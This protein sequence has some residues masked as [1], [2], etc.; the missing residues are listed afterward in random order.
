MT[1][2]GVEGEETARIYKVRRPAAEMKFKHVIFTHRDPN[3]S[4][5]L[6][7]VSVIIKAA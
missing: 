3:V 6:T 5:P 7:E 2:V 1:A 4:K